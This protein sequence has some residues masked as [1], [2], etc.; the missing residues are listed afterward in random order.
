MSGLLRPSR[1]LAFAAAAGL[2]LAGC[3]A[4]SHLMDVYS[5]VQATNIDTPAGEYR[6][7]DRP[8]LGVMLTSPSAP[9]ILAR[10]NNLGLDP[11]GDNVAAARL[12]FQ[13]SGRNCRITHSTEALHPEYEHTYVCA[14]R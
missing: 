13:R 6:I 5:G 4:S 10:G 3:A 2:C 11:E 9:T 14:T 7:W 8:D 1:A 12:W